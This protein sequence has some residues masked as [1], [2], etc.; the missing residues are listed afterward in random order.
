MKVYI[1]IYTNIEEDHP[2]YGRSYIGV[3]NDPDR[4]F[5]EHIKANTLIG[6]KLR[7]HDFDFDILDV[8]NS[9]E[10]AYEL[11]QKYIEE[12]N[13]LWPRGYNLESG[14]QGG[15]K[16][17]AET[18]AKLSKA[19]L[20]ISSETRAKLS[21]SHIGKKKSPETRKK[22]SRAQTGKKRSPETI[23]KMLE[24]R[25]INRIIKEQEL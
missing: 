11:E 25:R 3:S 16:P 5:C 23:A 19:A 24:S 17:S 18:I 6:N 21:K 9:Y 15:K 7:K 20:N 10:E 14:G 13:T 8:T 4:R 22:M 2:E 1:Y 12:L